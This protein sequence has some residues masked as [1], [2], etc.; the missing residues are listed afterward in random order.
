M[1]NFSDEC[2]KCEYAEH[3]LISQCFVCC[4]VPIDLLREI[5]EGSNKGDDKKEIYSDT[6][7]DTISDR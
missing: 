7:K 6:D 4:G 5:E 2:K 1:R 3:W